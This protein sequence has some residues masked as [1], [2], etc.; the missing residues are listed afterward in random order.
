MNKLYAILCFLSGLFIFTDVSAT[1][2]VGGSMSYEYL[3]LQ[4]NGNYRYRVTIKMYRDCAASTVPFDQEIDIGIYN[5][6]ADRTLS[7]TMTVPLIT[8]IPV[9]PPSGGSNCSFQ[10]NVCIRQAIYQ[11]LVDVSAS[12]LGYHL[13]FRRCCRNTQQNIIDD[14]GQTYYAFIPNTSIN[15]SSPF[16]TEVPAPY[17]CRNDLVS[18]YNTAKDKDGDSLVYELNTPWTGGSDSDP[19]PGLPFNM[20]GFDNVIYRN[21]YNVTNPFGNSGVATIDKRNGVTEIKAPGLG[22]YSIAI[23]VSE[24]RN[25]VLISKIRLDIQMIVIDCPPNAIPDIKTQTNALNFTVKEGEPLCFDVIGTDSDNDN[26]K[27]KG[28]GEI[29][30]NI[31]GSKAT[32]VEK[33]GT[34]TVSSQFCWTPPCGSSRITPYPATFEVND[35]GCPAKKKLIN[36]NITVE[37]FIGVGV[38]GGPSPI[39]ADLNGVVYSAAGQTGSTY[40]WT[41]TGGTIVAGQGNNSITVDWNN[42]SAGVVQVKE[43]SAGGC[44]GQTA[45]KNIVLLPAPVQPSI[46]GPD[47]VCSFGTGSKYSIPSTPNYTYSWSASGGN[48]VAG[49]NTTQIT[50]DWG[51]SGTGFVR[52]TQSNN[53]GC[54]SEPDTFRV[55]IIKNKIDSLLGSPS[56]CP[57]AVGIDY[58][59]QTPDPMAS[60]IWA[61]NQ[62]NIVSGGTSPL[63][64]VNWGEP[65]N[66]Y[67]EVYEINKFGCQ[68]NPVRMNV[69]IDHNLKGMKPLEEDTL[70]E[71]SPGIP[72]RVIH[73][74]G[75][76]YYWNISGGNLVQNDSGADV[77]ADWGATGMASISVAER[78]YDSVNNKACLSQPEVLDVYLAPVPKINPIIGLDELCQG[79]TQELY[80]QNGFQNSTYRWTFNGGSFNGQ[81]NDSIYILPVTAGN[82]TL[83]VI[84]TSQYGCVGPLNTKSIIIHPKPLTAGITGDPIICYPRY[85]SRPYEVQGF[86]TSTFNWTFDGGTV[87]SGQ[88]TQQ[89]L[90]DFNGQALNQIS[91]QEISDFGCPGDMLNLEVFADRPS[92]DLEVV[93][94]KLGDDTKMEITWDLINASRYNSKFL[95]QRRTKGGAWVL[96]GTTTDTAKTFYTDLGLNTDVNE[97]D[98][99][100]IGFN[101]CGDSIYSNIHRHVRI[102]GQKP[103]DDPYAVRLDWSRYTGLND[104]VNRYELYRRE[105]HQEFVLQKDHGLDTFDFYDDGTETF[106]Q[107]YRIKTIENVSGTVSWS[108]EICFGFD[109][110]LFVPTAFTPNGD[111]INDQFTWY[112]ASIRDFSIQIYDRWGE[113]I[114]EG[115]HANA[116]WNANYRGV[117]VPE[118]VYVFIIN[119]TGY[120]GRLQVVKG[121]LTVLR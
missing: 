72:Y 43:V 90:L 59:I 12:T 25:G 79:N 78:A 110:L 6:N 15:N 114:Y 46:S 41:V 112:H 76:T 1:H 96:A 39:C 44:M 60:Y 65:A 99:R 36:I 80:Y 74:N 84:E 20:P 2:L 93:S 113:R 115:D 97:Y 23:D 31:M 118:G 50:V 106:Q 104:G 98:Y 94:V 87:A 29:F 4:N 40:T 3:G 54:T 103:E 16:F 45:Q 102:V 70:C 9:D 33:S 26:I 11:G 81:G 62:G 77:I 108:N 71:F 82:F 109:P 17:I 58:Y 14:M 57:H 67:V 92:L 69:S 53:S 120:D 101:L 18:I 51:A 47:T 5:N 64:K 111:Q 100:I 55:R 116:Y 66:G 95:I 48:I 24:Y 91:V 32:F 63:I 7:K 83:T 21:G 42:V 73:T 19:M 10:P 22:R 28:T 88:G 49:A 119:Y 89:V 38:I 56:V 34:G 8:E 107:C 121:N 35:D 61:V 86:P 85:G 105:G 27:L 68:S 75:S 13:I 117:Q 37:P 30:V 52:V